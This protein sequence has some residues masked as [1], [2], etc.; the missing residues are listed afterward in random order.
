ME[1]KR[2]LSQSILLVALVTGLVLMIPGV[3]MTFTNEVNWNLADFIVAGALIFSTGLGYVVLMRYATNIA[4]RAAMI[5]ALG[6][7]FFMVWAN[8]AVGIIGSGPNPGNLLYAFVVAVGIVGAILSHF[9]ARGMERTMYAMASVVVLIAIIALLSNMQ[10]YP[11]SSI[12]EILGVNALFAV[13]FGT[14]G[15]LF[16]YVN[17]VQSHRV[18]KLKG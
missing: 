13:L 15:L 9:A 18:E 12:M 8:L 5:L 10:S 2:T 14:A 16:R 3:A 7:T 11:G 1:K 4:S 17:M 6:S